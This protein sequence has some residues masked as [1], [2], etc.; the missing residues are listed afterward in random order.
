MT[1][2]TQKKVIQVTECFAYGTA[3]S[4]KQLA[5]IL[6]EEYQVLFFYCRRN[7]SE[8]EIDDIDS[9]ITL[10]ELS[11]KGLFR[12]LK[13]TLKVRSF[14]DK[15]TH[16]IHGHSSYGGV[17]VRLAS[18]GKGVP[19]V[20]YSPR[21][22]SF[23]RKDI[24]WMVRHIFRIVEF[25]LSRLGFTI[26]CGPAE[27]KIGKKL[28]HKIININ[29]S[30]AIKDLRDNEEAYETFNIISVGRI[31]HQKSFDTFVEVA[32]ILGHIK[33]T[34]IGSSELDYRQSIIEK[35]GGLPANVQ[36]IDYMNQADL[37]RIISQSSAVFHPS[38]WE[39]LSRIL[40]ESLALGLPL[41]TSTCPSNMDCLYPR[42]KGQLS[43]QYDNGFACNTVTDYVAAITLLESDPRLV[44]RMRQASY[45]L[46][47]R[48]FDIV[49]T[50][51]KWVDLYKGKLKN[52][53]RF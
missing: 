33:F 10:I 11:S 20:F 34:W 25:S 44:S 36:I 31:C 9:G 21:A 48:E 41:V 32:N 35:N 46:A 37:F 52:E 5:D 23:L 7:E 3:K 47:K 14:I 26:S 53:Y 18:I 1:A 50:K 40:L 29:N 30:V 45:S 13:N 28:T 15:S 6:K 51:K 38:R 17:Y 22:Y 39:G 24:H 12:H 19:Y 43:G 8:S 2:I 27:F 42:L 4:I 16:A 49:K